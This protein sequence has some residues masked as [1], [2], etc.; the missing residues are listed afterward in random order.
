M[1]NRILELMSQFKSAVVY[2]LGGSDTGKTGL[3]TQL[4]NQ[5]VGDHTAILDADIGQ[6]GILPLTISLL[7]VTKPFSNLSEL[8]VVEQEFIPGYNLVLNLERN[9][10]AM[11][12]LVDQARTWAQYCLVDTTGFVSGPG[13]RLKRR[14]IEEVH[15]DLVVALQHSDELHPILRGVECCLLLSAVPSWVGRKSE[16]ERREN[17]NERLSSYFSN[18][19]LREIPPGTP[20]SVPFQYEQRLIGLYG[21]RFLGLGVVKGYEG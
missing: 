20:A 14:E 4:A 9:A 7:R 1:I 12:K 6:S 11:G 17:R 13:R 8:P 18:G 10:K 16:I 5:L 15:P 3:V 2:F 19:D 21:Q